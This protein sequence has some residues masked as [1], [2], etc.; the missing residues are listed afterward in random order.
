MG[1]QSLDD[2]QLIRRY[3]DAAPADFSPP[4]HFE[5]KHEKIVKAAVL[6]PIFL[7]QDGEWQVLLTK[8]SNNLSMHPGEVAFPGGKRDPE[9][10]D[11]EQT[12][13]REAKEEIGLDSKNVEVIGR[14]EAILTRFWTCVYPFVGLIDEQIISSLKGNPSEVSE[15]FSVPLR[16]FLSRTGFSYF[17]YR[18]SED[19]PKALRYYQFDHEGHIIKGITAAI[20]VNVASIL[21]QVKPEFDFNYPFHLIKFP[22]NKL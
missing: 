14:F 9:D 8:R 2:V 5:I 19:A 20:C 15:I 1:G 18:S 6:V 3:S 16:L 10:V 22:S 11:N 4:L 21:Y 12:A 13:L 17:D 7:G